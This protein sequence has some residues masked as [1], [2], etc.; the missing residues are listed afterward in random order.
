MEA[1][2]CGVAVFC[3]D[4]LRLNLAFKD[5]DDI[6]IITREPREVTADLDYF[7]KNP[8]ELYR[9]AESGRRAFLRTFDLHSQMAGRMKIL[10]HLLNE[11]I[12]G[13]HLK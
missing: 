7:Y 10:E 8:E 2:L 4:P 6:V 3:S 12:P 9:I 1:G 5:K 13:G 11:T